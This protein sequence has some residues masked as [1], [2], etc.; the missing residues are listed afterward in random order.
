MKFTILDVNALLYYISIK[1]QTSITFFS[2]KRI[3]EDFRGFW[4]YCSPENSASND[5]K[6]I[7]IPF[8]FQASPFNNQTSFILHSYIVV[9]SNAYCDISA[10]THHLITKCCDLSIVEFVATLLQ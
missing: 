6:F 4:I 1:L 8:F 9:R 7:F 2:P 3:L 10:F 5:T